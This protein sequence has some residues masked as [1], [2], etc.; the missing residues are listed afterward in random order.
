MAFLTAKRSS[1]ALLL[2]GLSVSLAACG[3]AAHDIAAI[4]AARPDLR[5]FSGRLAST[6]LAYDIDQR[7]ASLTVLAVDNAGMALLKARRLPRA[8]VRRHLSLHVLLDYYDQARLQSLPRGSSEV[9]STLLPASSRPGAGASGKVRIVAPG[10]G[11]GAGEPVA[12]LPMGLGPGYWRVALFVRSVYEAP[13]DISVLQVSAVMSG[14][15]RQ[16][17]TD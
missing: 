10:P 5:E 11:L 4:L 16:E 3:V 9:V 2:L 13:A 12:F 15:G 7:N 14:G 1:A 6:G 17:A 8:T